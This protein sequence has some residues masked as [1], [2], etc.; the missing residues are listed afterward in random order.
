MSRPVAAQIDLAA[1]RHNLN[2]VRSLAPGSKVMAVIKANA[3]G[4]G[5]LSAARALSTAEGFGVAA[6]D[7]AIAL[8]DAGFKQDICLL[9]GFHAA[10][11]LP[12]IARAGIATVVHSAEQLE[13]LESFTGPAPVTVWVK[14]DT[15]MH[16]IGFAPEQLDRV[17]K[18]L[19]SLPR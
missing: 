1:L 10:D 15:G 3:Y 2:R 5:L 8:R 9:T 7:E 16:R 6:L 12:E 14:I 4:H 18:R 19:S 11:E 13:Q 17:R